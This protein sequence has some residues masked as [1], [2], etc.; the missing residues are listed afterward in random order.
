MSMRIGGFQRFSMIDYPGHACAIIFTQGCNFRCPFCH[1]PELVDPAKFGELIPEQEVFD[2]L[3]TRKGKLDA[4]V[5]TGGEPTVQSGLLPFMGKIKAMG[6]LIKLDSNGSNPQ[7]LEQAMANKLVDYFAMDIKAPLEKYSVAT[8]SKVALENIQ[9]S[10][11]LIMRSGLPY[12]FRTTVVQSQLAEEDFHAIGKIIK[13]ARLYVLQ[14]F[15]PGKVLNPCFASETTYPNAEFE[16]IK[17][18]M[19]EYCKQCLV[20]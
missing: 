12:E 10:V 13:G 18:L 2:F 8:N 5:V 7:V 1:N 16:K 3:A 11:N 4:V 19:E 15:V 17:R 14:K 9:K 20:R 6:F